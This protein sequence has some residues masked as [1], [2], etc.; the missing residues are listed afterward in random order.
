M[1]R[2]IGALD[3]PETG[4]EELAQIIQL[5]TSLAGST[6]RLAN[7]AYFAAGSAVDTLNGALMRLGIREV[8]R[9]S[10]LALA[11]RWFNQKVDGYGWQPGDYCRISLVTALAAE[12]LAEHTGE[13]DPGKAYAAGLVHE[14][15]K[16][17][18]AYSCS[19]QFP[20]IREHID[21]A[22]GTWIDAERAVLGFSHVEI[23]TSLLRSWNFPENLVSAAHYNPPTAEVPAE[24]LP[25]VAHVH[26]AKYMATSMGTGVAED[27]FLCEINAELL[28]EWGLSA[29]VLE[30]VLPTVLERADRVLQEQL[31][32]GAIEL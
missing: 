3:D 25:L 13:V 6:L 30:S 18:V 28:E 27:G 29:E 9:L 23:S 14:I 10:A 11:G 19:D 5:D 26:A 15:G 2:L 31:S 22:G 17:A 20:A 12:G 21:A 32:T 24:F 7:S 4:I 1:P 8:Y 16:L